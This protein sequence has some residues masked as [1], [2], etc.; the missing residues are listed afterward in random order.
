LL[1]RLLLRLLLPPLL[2]PLLPLLPTPMRPPI[3]DGACCLTNAFQVAIG[4]VQWKL[5]RSL[6]RRRGWHND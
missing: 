1:L 2:P 4:A 6:R 5:G 3:S